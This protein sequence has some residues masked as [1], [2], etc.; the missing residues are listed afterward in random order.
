MV[1]IKKRESGK[2]LLATDT[3]CQSTCIPDGN[4]LCLCVPY[5]E[6]VKPRRNWVLSL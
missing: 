6:K 5:Q 2:A 4:E 1:T 3:I